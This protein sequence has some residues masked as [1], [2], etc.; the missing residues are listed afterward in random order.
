[1]KTSPVA[2]QV[3]WSNEA[4]HRFLKFDASLAF[5]AAA[6]LPQ[7]LSAGS[8][9]RATTGGGQL[10]P[11]LQLPMGAL[12]ARLHRTAAQAAENEEAAL[13]VRLRRQ[14]EE[15]TMPWRDHEVWARAGRDE[16]A[17][18]SEREMARAR[19]SRWCYDETNQRNVVCLVGHTGGV[20]ADSKAKATAKAKAKAKA[21]PWMQYGPA[22]LRAWMEVLPADSGGGNCRGGSS[23]TGSAIAVVDSVV[24]PYE[25]QIAAAAK[26][27]AKVRDS[28]AKVKGEDSSGEPSLAVL[29]D[30][31]QVF[32][33]M[34]T[35]TCALTVRP[36]LR[37]LLVQ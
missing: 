23:N 37:R 29:D 4:L 28:L 13:D 27:L 8:G 17:V 25:E 9:G 19:G 2:R 18:R 10:P 32:D 30:P 26:L 36:S 33:D 16:A 24:R 3:E 34:D 22:K 1:M 21:S 6:R 20:H 15:A 5:G 12:A 7:T 11:Q 35:G 14:H 31:D